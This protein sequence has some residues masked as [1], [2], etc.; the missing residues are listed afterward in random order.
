MKI[1]QIINKFSKLNKI[2]KKIIL[3]INDF[4]IGIL[5][6]YLAISL[7]IDTLNI[8]IVFY[9]KAF[10]IFPLLAILVFFYF[11]IYNI[12]L[13]FSSEKDLQLFSLAIFFY[14]I[15]IG[16]IS[17]S[18]DLSPVPKSLTI[19]QPAIFFV[20]ITLN[21]TLISYLLR[22]DKKISKET[23]CLLY[24]A[25]Q[26]GAET[27]N[28]LKRSSKYQIIGFIDDKKEQ[29]NR[30]IDGV[31]IYSFADSLRLIQRGVIDEIILTMPNITKYRRQ[32][33]INKLSK[34]KLRVRSIPPI[35]DIISGNK[36]IAEV[37]NLEISDF[38]D[39]TIDFR[40]DK[41][42]NLYNKKVVMV[43]GAG[44]SIGSELC[45]QIIAYSPLKLILLD[46]SELNLFNVH[47]EL[48]NMSSNTEITPILSNVNNV[49]RLEFIFSKFQPDY[50]LHAA[51]YKHVHLVE[52]NIVDGVENNIFGTINIID[53]AFEYNIEKFCLISTDKAVDP[54]NIMGMTKR[55]SELYLK[56]KSA[57]SSKQT[58]SHVVRFGNVLGSSG[59]VFKIFSDQIKNGGPV[60]LTHKDV[61]RYF[62]TIPEAVGLILLSSTFES[63]GK[64]YILDMGDPIKIIELAKK[65]ISLSGYMLKDEKNNSGDIEIKIIGL[66]KGEKLHEKLAYSDNLLP[67]EN[68]HI[69]EAKEEYDID[70]NFI[71]NI[72]LLK[73]FLI[74]GSEERVKKQIE[75]F[76]II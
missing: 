71:E 15:C 60:L 40:S 4:I 27:L 50:V 49:N 23:V 22:I 73:K 34:Y 18:V 51:A 36:N 20:S 58:E 67:T 44:G 57:N 8:D 45:R 63:F 43:T 54:E 48:E 66:K 2:N 1:S 62:M 28:S 11:G 41:V 61:T 21:R 52:E 25:G 24:G 12:V 16:I 7:R 31:L 64:I 75:S 76:K 6:T 3:L 72:N 10:L 14:A 56:Y 70:E 37:N 47:K 35:E 74:S 65:M 55:I 17:I 19:I 13:R 5:S 59:S 69:L 38:L 32:K 26:A 29:Q 30:K 68:Q 42:V 33:I 46:H 53:K 39:R 9:Q